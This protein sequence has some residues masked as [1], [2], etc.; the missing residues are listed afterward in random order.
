LKVAEIT[1]TDQQQVH[2]VLLPE[3]EVEKAL[4][5]ILDQAEAR[6]CAGADIEGSPETKGLLIA[7]EIKSRSSS[8][9]KVYAD[10]G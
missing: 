5:Q 1:G 4:I 3:N 2:I 7:A 6:L 10:R 8:R 9:T